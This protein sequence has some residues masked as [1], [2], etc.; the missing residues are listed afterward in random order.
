MHRF[1]YIVSALILGMA[2]DAAQASE[3]PIF[4][5][6]SVDGYMISGGFNFNTV[7]DAPDSGILVT[8]TSSDP[9]AFS[10]INEGSVTVETSNGTVVDWGFFNGRDD[11]RV[12]LPGGAPTLSTLLSS[13]FTIDLFGFDIGDNS[14]TIAGTITFSETAPTPTPL[15]AALPL[16]AAGLGGLGFFGRRRRK[17][18]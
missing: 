4:A 14:E 18:A 1:I 2:V 15:P 10:P 3:V 8:L 17:V 12:L 5:S 16:F 9:S 11:F 7:S 13:S 6:G